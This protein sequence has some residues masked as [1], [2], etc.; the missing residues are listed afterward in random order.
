MASKY[1]W[2]FVVSIIGLA[3]CAIRARSVSLKEGQPAPQFTLFGDDGV[4]YDMK[5]YMKGKVVLFFYPLDNS[6]FC[7]KQACSIG[8][9]YALLR[10]N[11]ITVFGINHQSIE[12][13]AAFKKKHHLPFTLLSD[14]DSSIAK[15]YGAYTP[16]YTKRITILIQDGRIVS[17]L[18]NIDVAHHAEQIMQGFQKA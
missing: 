11:G 8:Q 14:P 3:S 13:H 17:V 15:Q 6:Y 1:L 9:D 12:S 4:C 7:T 18:Q 16:F 2:I 5:D 10:K